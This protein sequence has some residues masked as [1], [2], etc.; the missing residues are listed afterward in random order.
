EDLVKWSLDDNLK[1]IIY[2]EKQSKP[3]RTKVISRKK[4]RE[5]DQD[6]LADSDL[7]YMKDEI[8]DEY[9]G[10][11]QSDYVSQVNL[12]DLLNISL[13]TESAISCIDWDQIDQ[14]VGVY[15]K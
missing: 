7:D 9:L 12:D 1:Q 6:T 11:E 13:S 2:D 3:S 4:S 10:H 8:F 15:K 5:M 14:I